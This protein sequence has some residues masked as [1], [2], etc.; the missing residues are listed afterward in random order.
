MTEP[1]QTQPAASSSP[2]FDVNDIIATAKSVI[3]APAAHFQSMPTGGG[4]IEPLIFI[5]AMSLVS[6]FI[7][8]L[9]SF[10]GSPVGM[11]A[12]GLAAIIFVPIAAAIG[13]FIGAGILYVIWKLMG[14]ERDYEASFRCLA[15]VS[16]I[17]PVTVVLHLVP[18]LGTVVGLA[19]GAFL[20]IEAS[21]AVHG[22]PRRAAQW[23][24]GI[25]AVVLIIMNVGAERNARSFAD[26]AERLNQVLEQYKD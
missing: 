20:L 23:V 7:S 26:E 25:L 17:Y 6:G 2:K 13:S 1:E 24:F 3:T 21:V 15:A 8:G 5:V 19:W 4:L 11:L 12:Y 18:Y 10:V 9:L 14:S 16:A 22:R